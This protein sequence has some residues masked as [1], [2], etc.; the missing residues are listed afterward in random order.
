[1]SFVLGKRII[2]NLYEDRKSALLK[3]NLLWFMW[4]KYK[5]RRMNFT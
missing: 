3:L 1:M 2:S 4:L 5:E